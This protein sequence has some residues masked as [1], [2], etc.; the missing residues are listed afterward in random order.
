MFY[1]PCI[2]D[3]HGKILK[4]VSQQAMTK[5]QAED[6]LKRNYRK[7]WINCEAIPQLCNTPG[8]HD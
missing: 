8:L 4:K 5:D 2:T 6:Y 1:Y 7:Q 3:H